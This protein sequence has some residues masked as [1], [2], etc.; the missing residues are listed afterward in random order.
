MKRREKGPSPAEQARRRLEAERLRAKYSTDEQGRLRF[1]VVLEGERNLLGQY[2]AD[3][4]DGRDGKPPFGAGLIE[5]SPDRFD[6]LVATPENLVA[7]LG[8]YDAYK[9]ER[10][11][12]LS[13]RLG[14]LGT[15]Y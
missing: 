10:R 15:R 13:E 1:G 4:I 14:N 2:A 11:R 9:E 6:K 12:Q 3:F 8:E 5:G 7:F